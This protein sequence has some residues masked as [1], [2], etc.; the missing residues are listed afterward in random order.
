MPGSNEA[1]A[2]NAIDVGWLDVGLIPFFGVCRFYNLLFSILVAR[3]FTITKIIF[4][5]H[6]TPT[7]LS[8]AYS[9]HIATLYTLKITV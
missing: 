7:V 4:A 9:L 8:G 3:L 1:N 6:R 5:S 2:T